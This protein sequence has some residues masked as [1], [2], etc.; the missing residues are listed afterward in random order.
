MRGCFL[1]ALLGPALAV[2]LASPCGAEEAQD[3]EFLQNRLSKI[4]EFEPTGREI[5]WRNPGTGNDGLVM[6]ERT[7]FLDPKTPCR[8][9]ILTLDR[10]G[11]APQILR[12]TGCR[13]EDGD[14]RLG[15]DGEPTLLSAVERGWVQAGPEFDRVYDD[16]LVPDDIDGFEFADKALPAEPAP[17]SE[18][19]ALQDLVADA[20][21]LDDSILQDA[22]E[23]IGPDDLASAELA[24]ELNATADPQ[25]QAVIALPATG[26]LPEPNCTDYPVGG[27]SVEAE[28]LDLVFL[29]DTTSSMRSEL[30]DLKAGVMSSVRVLL[31]MV[32]SLNIGFVAF[33]DRNDSYV[34]SA[35]QLTPMT[36][37][38]LRRLEI[39]VEGLKAGG[40]GDRPEAIDKAMGVAKDMPWRPT[41]LGQIVVIGDAPAHAGARGRTLI[42]AENF[43][44]D[45]P[46]S[47]ARRKVSAVYTGSARR[48][49]SRKFFH[50][51]AKHG[52][53]CFTSDPQTLV[54][55]VLLSVLG[56]GRSRPAEAL[57]G[58]S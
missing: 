29:L 31:R 6:V 46:S 42:M 34:T 26:L 55:N 27:P 14:W 10:G 58:P 4:L 56:R 57:P 35:F 30:G 33:R 51:L 25:A 54:E 22:T 20:R 18:K 47:A 9:F 49:G 24:A 32:S 50:H 12:G 16:E 37:D 41:A 45:V 17:P 11:S 15:A 38:S 5:S 1:R 52:G 21:R 53:G 43:R 28:E 48:R 8:D 39:F 36:E 40:G 13:S 23:E 3:L 19:L 7:Y 2:A 44:G